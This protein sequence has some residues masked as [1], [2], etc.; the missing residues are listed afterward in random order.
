MPGTKQKRDQH[1]PRKSPQG[2]TCPTCLNHTSL[3]YKYSR[4]ASTG[5]AKRRGG[6]GPYPFFHF[7]VDFYKTI[8]KQHVNMHGERLPLRFVSLVDRSTKLNP[9]LFL[10][11]PQNRRKESLIYILVFCS[12]YDRAIRRS[13]LAGRLY[14]S[15]WSQTGREYGS[16]IAGKRF[17]MPMR[18]RSGIASSQCRPLSF[19]PYSEPQ[20]QPNVLFPQSESWMPLCRAVKP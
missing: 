11:F 1:H 10:S 19:A 20:A 13:R 4:N 6:Y 18:H 14:I 15:I 8:K 17:L 3:F 7:W 12:R 2:I 16:R 5:R 9:T